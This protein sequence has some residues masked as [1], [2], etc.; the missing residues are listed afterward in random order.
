MVALRINGQSRQLDVP[1]DTPLLHI[2]RDVLGLTATKLGC[3]L[4]Q[5]GACTVLV[6]GE[7]RMACRL[8]VGALADSEIITLEG[9]GT[10]DAPHPL[11]RAFI[12]ENAAQCGYC[13]SGILMRAAALLERSS[14]PDEAEIRTALR[15]NLCRC[16]AHNRVVRAVR[17]AAREGGAR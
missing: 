1:A 6:D 15:D 14:A 16:G 5:C 3:S 17:R 2:L 11:Q 13:T 4:E 7:A 12:E 10:P 9:L 8:P